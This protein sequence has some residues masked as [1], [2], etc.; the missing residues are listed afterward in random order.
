VVSHG[1]VVKAALCHVLGL[2]SR[3]LFRIKQDNT[4]VSQVELTGDI[5]RVLLVNDTC[6]LTHAAD[7][8]P[9]DV[10]T[11]ANEAAPTF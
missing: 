2:E 6:H 1:G 5:R 7:L 8:I 4:A 9:R 3:A 10:L 11:D